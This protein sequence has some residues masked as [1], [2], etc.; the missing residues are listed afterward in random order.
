MA[1]E[2]MTDD[3]DNLLASTDIGT[4]FLDEN[5]Q[6]RKFT[7][8]AANYVKLQ[9]SDIG[10]EITDFALHIDL[11]DFFEKINEVYATSEPFSEHATARNSTRVLVRI[12]PYF[13]Q[14]K[15]KGAI[16]NFIDMG[17]VNPG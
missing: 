13:S 6:I 7:R 17:D 4:I 2:E 16:V 3:V 11:P 8:A 5:L 10:R 14:K 12:T 15:M 9:T 1:L